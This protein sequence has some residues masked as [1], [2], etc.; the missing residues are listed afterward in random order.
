LQFFLCYNVILMKSNIHP[1]YYEEAIVSCSCGNTFTTG[2]TKK[3]I[4]VEVCY[5]CHPFY[6]G[7]HRYLDVEGR[8]ESFQKKQ[9]K[10]K[11]YQAKQSSKK[12]EEKKEYQPKTLKEL[13]EA[14]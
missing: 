3:E 6:T 7:K 12:N 14:L 13:L 2:S 8:V 5:E 10:A 11:E 9:E 4:H 1:S